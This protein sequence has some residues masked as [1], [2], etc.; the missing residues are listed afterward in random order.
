MSSSE[1]QKPAMSRSS[2]PMLAGSLTTPRLR[3]SRR[4]PTSPEQLIPRRLAASRPR[5]SSMRSTLAWVSR[6]RTMAS[7]SPAP[8]SCRS[9]FT[10]GISLTVWRS[11]QPADTISATPAF[12][13]SLAT[14]S[15]Q[16]ASG[17]TSFPKSSCSN[18]SRPI[19]HKAIKGDESATTSMVVQWGRVA[20]RLA[21]SKASATS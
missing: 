4:T 7:D 9:R 11:I 8:K 6:A 21:S 1:I 3:A 2:R 12:P 15:V 10:S 13:G 19:R 18:S 20:R 14:T 5:R 16:T 17:R